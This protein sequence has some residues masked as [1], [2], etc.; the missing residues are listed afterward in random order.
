MFSGDIWLHGMVL[1][2]LNIRKVKR[3]NH[4]QFVP[5]ISV[6]NAYGVNFPENRNCVVS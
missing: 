1:K 2:G 3:V 5:N 6:E 4:S